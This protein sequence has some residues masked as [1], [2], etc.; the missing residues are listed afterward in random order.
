MQVRFNGLVH[1]LK[2]V[3]KWARV[4]NILCAKSKIHTLWQ[5][6][7]TYFVARII[8]ILCYKIYTHTLLQELYTYFVARVMYIIFCKSYKLT[9]WQESYFFS[10]SDLL[11]PSIVLCCIQ[12]TAEMEI[13][14]HT[15]TQNLVPDELPP[16]KKSK[17]CL[18]IISR[19][20]QNKLK[21]PKSYQTSVSKINHWDQIY[22]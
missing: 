20:K 7:Y 14:S 21:L 15:N 19:I 6:L 3:L 22:I 11:D 12:R 4:R 10:S 2:I 17:N 5:E 9:L 16:L 13:L 8:Y 18:K 1:N